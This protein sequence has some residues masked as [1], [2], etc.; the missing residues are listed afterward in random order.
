M[1]ND[2]QRYALRER[3]L[4]LA[5]A[6]DGAERRLYAVIDVARDPYL[7]LPV[8]EGFTD[9]TQ[10]LFR[11]KAREELGDQTAWLARVDPQEG[12]LDWL[13][14]EGWGRRIVAFVVT[15]LNLT[16]LAAH[17]RK[18]T[19]VK[20]K[21][22]VEYFFRFYDPQVLRQYLP[23]FAAREHVMFF[24]EIDCCAIE[25]TRRPNELMIG[26]SVGGALVWET[27]DAGETPR[28]PETA[29]ARALLGAA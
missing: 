2:E 23:V 17:L 9:D 27:H 4:S 25:N 21:N 6:Q 12:L 3:L 19:K 24:R 10:C 22:G 28:S 18:F 26:R 1:L 14:E 5:T 29:F 20:D 13:I 15:T 11:G 8:I 7:L 16:R